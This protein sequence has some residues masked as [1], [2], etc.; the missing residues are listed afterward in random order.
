MKKGGYFTTVSDLICSTEKNRRISLSST[1][2]NKQLTLYV[3]DVS[4]GDSHDF[5]SN[6]KVC[7]RTK[8]LYIF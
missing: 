6:F 4:V 5:S 1:D 3:F 7:M 2:I 8:S